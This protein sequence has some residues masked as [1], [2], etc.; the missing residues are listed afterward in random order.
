LYRRAQQTGARRPDPHALKLGEETLFIMSASPA[1]TSALAA[2]SI[3][4]TLFL[5]RGRIA[6]LQG[7]DLRIE[8][9]E[10][11]AIMGPSGSG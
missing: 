11:A 2:L 8:R 7:A 5:G 9:G 10:F 6:V 4:K 3:T 1:D